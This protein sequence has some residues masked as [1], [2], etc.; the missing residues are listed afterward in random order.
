MCVAGGG[1]GGGN[2]INDFYLP[3][4]EREALSVNRCNTQ[5]HGL[6]L[7]AVCCATGFAFLRATTLEDMDSPSSSSSPSWSSAGERVR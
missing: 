5:R 7:P 6:G 2:L 1:E 3:E 4:R